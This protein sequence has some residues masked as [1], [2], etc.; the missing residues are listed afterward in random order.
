M[1]NPIDTDFV[2]YLRDMFS[3]DDS[4]V[5]DD[6]FVEYMRDLLSE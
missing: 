6:D 2:T 3:D 4:V 1:T 5:I